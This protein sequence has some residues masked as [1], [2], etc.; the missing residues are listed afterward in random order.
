MWSEQRLGA[1]VAQ[2]LSASAN[3]GILCQTPA[4]EVLSRVRAGLFEAPHLHSRST[5]LRAETVRD[6]VRLEEG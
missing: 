5:P 4:L 3:L 1:V 2:L 6:C